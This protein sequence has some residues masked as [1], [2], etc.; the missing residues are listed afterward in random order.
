MHKQSLLKS[1]TEDVTVVS[2]ENIKRYFVINHE[3]QKHLLLTL[4]LDFPLKMEEFQKLH[5][6]G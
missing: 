6:S 5:H 3:N 1:G 2:F 4:T